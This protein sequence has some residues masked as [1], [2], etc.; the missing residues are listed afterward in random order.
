MTNDLWIHPSALF[1]TGALLL[2]L[3]RG[4][5]RKAFLLLVP[6]AAFVVV[7][8]LQ[9]GIH[10]SVN[11]LEWGMS[12]G[13]VD[14]LSRIFAFIMALMGF[15][16]TLFALQVRNNVEHVAAWVYVA[17]SLGVILAG[18]YLALF[19]FWELMAFSS[20]FL[21]WA[22][23]T[24]ASLAAGFRYLLIHGLGG[25]ILLTGI[26][27]HQQAAGGNFS[28]VPMDVT[29][30]GAG[31]WLILIGFLLN[32]AAPPL[33]AWMPDAYGEGTPSGSVVMSAFTTKTAVYALIRGFTGLPL[34]LPLGVF[35][36]LFGVIYAMLQNDARRLLAYHIISQVGYMVA[37]IG[38][39]S[40]LAVSGACA[41]AF[42]NVLYKSL[43]FM[44]TGS[45]L[46]MTG[47]SKFSELGGLYRKMP[48]T[49]VYTLIGGLS[50]SAFPL[51]AGFV[52]K[53]MIVTA[54][55]DKHFLFYA[56]LLSLASSGT[57]LSTT[58]KLTY[59]IWFGDSRCSE[60]T[61]EK[62]ADPPGNMEAAMA[63]TAFLCIFVGCYYP[64]LYNMLPYPFTYNPYSA[65]HL[66][67]TFQFMFF[68]V[69]GFFL[70]LPMFAPKPYLSLDWDWF[71]RIGARY[72]L[73]FMNFCFSRKETAGQA[74]RPSL[75]ETIDRL[76][77]YPG[78][79]FRKAMLMASFLATG[80]MPSLANVREDPRSWLRNAAF[81]VGLSVFMAVF[82][83]AVMSILFFL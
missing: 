45:I 2:P 67:E 34:L 65:Y 23:K 41:H 6:L 36:V 58:L 62:A 14:A 31:G 37:G 11:F 19:L 42:V 30:L 80:F 81:P 59:L 21:V 83:L 20:V 3:F 53:A 69:V 4:K 52:T 5:A 72:F 76:L 29:R 43:L 13:R 9:D 55:F 57:F 66:S 32:A 50:I 54:A 79:F 56:F 48:R 7:I 49:L 64:F 26:V 40:G 60:K 10:G 18:D 46:S 15:I 68:T 1:L 75:E 38:I 17:G 82:F 35:M 71:Y 12:F 47:K 24:P 51:F 77:D 44:G 74:P 78:D 61:L 27:L 63:L 33:H 28:F 8:T 16:G 70:M 25:I 73:R 39:G 22:R